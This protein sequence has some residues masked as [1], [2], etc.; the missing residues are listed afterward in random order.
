V[1]KDI[2]K[3]PLASMTNERGAKVRAAASVLL[4]GYRVINGVA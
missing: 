1:P 4:C 3:V 2:P